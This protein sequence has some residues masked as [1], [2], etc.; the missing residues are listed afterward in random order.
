MPTS[1]KAAIK[2]NTKHLASRE[3]EFSLTANALKPGFFQRKG[4]IE[5]KD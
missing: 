1:G 3:S 4:K 2:Q 5:R